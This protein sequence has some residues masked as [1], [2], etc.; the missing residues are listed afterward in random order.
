LTSEARQLVPHL[1]NTAKQIASSAHRELDALFHRSRHMVLAV[2]DIV[3]IAVDTAEDFVSAEKSPLVAMCRL[4]QAGTHCKSM[5]E[6]CRDE[7]G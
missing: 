4:L 3:R 6:S 5:L 1:A 2:A 7:L